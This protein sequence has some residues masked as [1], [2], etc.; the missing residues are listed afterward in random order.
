[1]KAVILAGGKGTRMRP[2]TYTRVKS[3]IPFLNKPV[4]EH[5]V[6]KLA[7]QGFD[8]IVLTTN[9]KTE[10]ITEY[11]GD[12]SK[13]D[14]NFTV[15]SEKDPLGTAGS[16]KNA[17]G[18]LDETF[19]VIQGDNIS[20]IDI[21]DL[22]EQHKRMGGFA[23][24]SLVE[25]EDP[26]LFGIAELKG[27]E[28]VR[29]QEKPKKDEAFSSLA[30]DGIYILEPEVLDMIPLA[31]YDFSKNLFPK[32]LAQGRKICGSVTHDFWRDV[33]TPKDYL[34]ATHHFIK[35]QHMIAEGCL[36]RGSRIIESV[37]GRNCTITD[38]AVVNSILFDNIEVRKNADIKHCII[39]SDCVIG[40]NVD[41][42]P[43]AVL[44]DNVEIG[45]DCTVRGNARIGPNISL[46]RDRIIEG[47][48][49]PEGID[50]SD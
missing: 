32:M 1:M 47:V 6:T 15:I 34:E 46:K 21:R 19:V 30:N 10:Q 38:A 12:G 26:S 14:C 25:V 29:F 36:V 27:N 49:T 37:L 3:M 31:F 2:L 11:F 33:G 45:R 35:G 22:Y 17:M 28:I 9:Y 18:C 42:Y 44:G 48:I 43:G 5:I 24:I 8:D 16:V 50:T 20:E 13:F 4:L 40:E 39:G 41:I 7:K 23:T